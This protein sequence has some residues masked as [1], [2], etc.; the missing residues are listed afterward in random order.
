[1][2]VPRWIAAFA[3]LH[4]TYDSGAQ[5][6]VAEPRDA[7]DTPLFSGQKPYDFHPSPTMSVVKVWADGEL[8]KRIL[9]RS[10]LA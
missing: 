5:A 7:L 10:F 9:V 4:S 2:S 3:P 8:E 1:M 6:S